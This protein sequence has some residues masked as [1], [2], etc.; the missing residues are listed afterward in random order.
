LKLIL[1]VLIVVVAL[2]ALRAYQ[3]SQRTPPPASA[4]AKPEDMVKCA[5]CQVNLPR[6]EALYSSRQFYCCPEHKQLHQK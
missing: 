4:P 1:I 5:Y 3:R 2:M 6:S